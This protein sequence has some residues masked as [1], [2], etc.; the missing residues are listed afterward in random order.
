MQKILATSYNFDDITK[1]KLKTPSAFN[2]KYA[3]FDPINEKEFR[4][5]TGDLFR[6]N[7]DSASDK[8]LSNKIIKEL[9][10]F[11]EV[12]RRQNLNRSSIKTPTEKSH[13]FP[14]QK[15]QVG[16]PK[17]KFS[18]KSVADVLTIED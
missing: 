5:P 16:N 7:L 2:D 10:N 18:A 14:V 11:V 1:S 12:D 9:V 3:L 13:T 15:S 4:P 8:K 6:S 17:T